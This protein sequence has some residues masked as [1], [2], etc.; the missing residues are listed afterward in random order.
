MKH[1]M[2]FLLLVGVIIA[3]MLLPACGGDNGESNGQDGQTA[4]IE[5]TF[6]H[7]LPP[8]HFS[9]Q[10]CQ[11]WA[12]LVEKKT[13]GRVKVNVYPA[14][15]LGATA[16]HLNML[17][18][19][20]VDVALFSTAYSPGRFPLT[21][22]LTVPFVI[23]NALVGTQVAT[24]LREQGYMGQEWDDIK[25]L[26]IFTNHPYSLFTKDKKIETLDDIKGL[27]VRTAGGM[28][29]PVEEALGA[30][31]VS[32]ALPEIY[33]ALDKG[34]VDGLIFGHETLISYALHE[35]INYVCRLGAGLAV[36]GIGMNK[37]VWE[38]LPAD[39]QDAII[40]ASEQAVGWEDYVIEL[41][42]RQAVTQA[43]ELGVEFYE[44]PPAE[45]AKLQNLVAPLVD[46]WIA[47]RVAKGAPA[48]EF[49]DAMIDLVR[50]YGY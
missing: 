31:S 1:K 44:L 7:F 10:Y 13:D 38:G 43:M 48:Q 8:D 50:A 32:V 12:D 37:T 29:T 22:L 14:A 4:E 46:N 15:A 11:L 34:V 17:E 49:Y 28:V 39:I 21:E 47:E 33:E 42:D 36:V 27:K 18:T 9:G 45:M 2:L 6:S 24:E 16:D 3:G 35:Q 26:T 5:L 40:F 23:P 25:L 30:V 41:K 19:G 20:T